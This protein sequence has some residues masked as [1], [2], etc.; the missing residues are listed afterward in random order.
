MQTI[1][2][3]D[4]LNALGITEDEYIIIYEKIKGVIK[5]INVQ[6]LGR[7]STDIEVKT[8]KTKEN[9]QFSVTTFDI[10]TNRKHIT[11]SGSFCLL[12]FI[13]LSVTVCLLC[14]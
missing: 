4:I 10:A 9:N 8:I 13:R 5:M 6:V 3:K 7:F 14:F 12:R 2:T 11:V 1:S